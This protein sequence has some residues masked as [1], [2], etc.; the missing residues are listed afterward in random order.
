MGQNLVNMSDMFG[1]TAT[2]PATK[3]S[4]DA[5]VLESN[6][7]KSFVQLQGSNSAT[8]K[9]VMNPFHSAPTCPPQGIMCQGFPLL[10]CSSD[11][12]TAVF[13]RPLPSQA[14]VTSKGHGAWRRSCTELLSCLVNVPIYLNYLNSKKITTFS[15]K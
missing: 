6:A 2:A 10:H 13:H 3:Q 9:P 11:N 14:S 7:H 8:K 15:Y 4:C 1:V 12:T 5:H